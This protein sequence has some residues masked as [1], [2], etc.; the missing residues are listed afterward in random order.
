[1]AQR[2]QRDS[3]EKPVSALNVSSFIWGIADDVLRDVY[4]RGKYRDVI[5]PMTVI[6]RLDAVLEP[7]KDAVLRMKEQLDAA[8][9]SESGRR[10]APGFRRG[11]LQRFGLSGYAT[12]RRAPVNSSCER[13]LSLTW[14][15][16]R[17]TCRRSWR[18]SG[19]ATRFR[20]WWRQ[21]AAG[22]PAGKV[23]GQLGQPQL[24]TQS[25]NGD[26]SVRL[27]WP[28]QPRHGYGLR[29]TNSSLQR[30]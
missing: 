29:G 9:D 30:G 14:T 7:N 5:L 26:G 21:D 17:P 13:T 19:F 11:I 12:S 8:G 16:S 4:V 28:G 2:G 10:L 24:L 1:M 22:V 20:R 6:R 3:R 23:P 18:S 25:L 15:V 27:A